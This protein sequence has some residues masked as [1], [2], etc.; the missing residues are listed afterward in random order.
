[1]SENLSKLLSI[2][3]PAIVDAPNAI[4]TRKLIVEESSGLEQEL[5]SL[6]TEKNGFFALESA[7]LVRPLDHEGEPQGIL[8]WNDSEAWKATYTFALGQS[9]FFAEDIFG[10][11][12]CIRA[13][14]VQSFDPETGHFTKIADTL[15]GWARWILEDH[16]VRTGWPL[17]HQWQEQHGPLLPGMRLLPKVPFMCGG[18]FSVTN[19]YELQDVDGMRFR[20][21]IANQLIGVPDGTKIVFKVARMGREDDV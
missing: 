15:E 17:A 5:C 7:L 11:Q 14:S 4:A 13:N 3:S 18:E 16:R 12:F 2:S 1:M 21:S 9:V 10:V 6:L 20:A 8:Q 19:L